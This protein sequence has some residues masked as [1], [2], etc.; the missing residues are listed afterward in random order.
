MK[1]VFK[2]PYSYLLVQDD[3]DWY[4]TFFSGGPFEVDICVKL[5]EGE[6]TRVSVSQEETAKLAQEFQQNKELY[7]GRRIIPSVVPGRKR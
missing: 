6:I 4:L 7:K 3:A 5:T 1:I 2:E